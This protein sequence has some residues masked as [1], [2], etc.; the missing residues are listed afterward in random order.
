MIP[1]SATTIWRETDN[2]KKN[3]LLDL[4][5]QQP[6]DVRQI[7]TTNFLVIPVTATTIWCETNH[8]NKFSCDTYH[9]NNYL[10]WDRSSRQQISLWYLSR[11]QLFDVRQITTTN[12]LVIPI[13]ATTIWRETDHDNKFPCDTYHGNNYLTWDRSRQHFLVIP[14]TATTIWRETDH[15]NNIFLW[16]ISRQQLFDV[17]QTTTTNF[18]VIPITATILCE[19][20]Y[21]NHY[22][23]RDRSRQQHFLVKSITATAI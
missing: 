10:T 17:R 20:Y 16:Y 21:G 5:R 2:D 11:Q 13:T 9:G 12:F 7:T 15:D 23:M 8:D 3:F 18:L 19:A 1:I 14:V 6:F 22:F 4:S